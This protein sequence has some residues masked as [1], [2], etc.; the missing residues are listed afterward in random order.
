MLARVDDTPPVSVPLVAVGA[1]VFRGGE[2]L[3]VRRG[4]EPA[5]GIWAVPGGAVRAGESLVQAAEREVLE[6]T[7]V[8][9][10]AGEVV[11]AFDVI[12]RDVT[13]VLR[14]HY[15]V[16]DLL[17]AWVSGEPRAGDDAAEARW[18]RLDDLSSLEVSSET[19]R[20]VERL[21]KGTDGT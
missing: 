14:Y 3:L 5:R 8:V 15:V 10:R 9:V 20:L 19:L 6:E 4:R 13:G 17:A 18:Q 7:G 2:V 12:D 11:H 16:V 1:V 21:R